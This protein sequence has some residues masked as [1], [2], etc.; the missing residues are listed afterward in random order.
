[1]A[2]FFHIVI[3]NIHYYVVYK[4]TQTFFRVKEFR[5]RLGFSKKTK[6]FKTDRF[7]IKCLK[8]FGLFS[9]APIPVN[10]HFVELRGVM[11][12]IRHAKCKIEIKNLLLQHLRE[13]ENTVRFNV[14]Q[15]LPQ[16]RMI[17]YQLTE[18]NTIIPVQNTSAVAS[19]DQNTT[20]NEES[21][22]QTQNNTITKLW[23]IIRQL[24][25]NNANLTAQLNQCA[26]Q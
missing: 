8:D 9:M 21:V 23:Q 11:V 3:C 12:M 5:D 1:M 17:N 6:P 7:E 25:V 4:D 10:S 18:T 15:N 16:S 22:V 19:Y 13:L 26:S 24:Q 2:V 20:M 14:S